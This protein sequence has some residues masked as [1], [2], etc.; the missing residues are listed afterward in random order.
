MDHNAKGHSQ[1]AG[2]QILPR[3]RKERRALAKRLK[4]SNERMNELLQIQIENIA[5]D[6]LPTGQKVKLK[7]EQIL[8]KKKELSEKYIQF[9]E[10]NKGNIL[11]VE[12]DP[13]KPED[14]QVVCLKEDTSEIKWLFHY[15]DLEIVFD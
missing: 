4:I 12:R 7:T 15:S 8:K 9:V 6:Y 10:D 1:L 11:T 5:I 2:N 3:N 13:S 14:A